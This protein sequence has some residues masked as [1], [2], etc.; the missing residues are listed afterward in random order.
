MVCRLLFVVCSL[1]LVV[2]IVRDALARQV[3][4][5]KSVASLHNV[6]LTVLFVTAFIVL[7]RGGFN[8]HSIHV[9]DAELTRIPVLPA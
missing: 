7:I 8:A 3:R 4:W 2:Q 9:S 6:E 1:L 5:G